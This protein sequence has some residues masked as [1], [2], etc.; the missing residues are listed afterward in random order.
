MLMAGCSCCRGRLSFCHALRKICPR[1]GF[2]TYNE[3]ARGLEYAILCGMNAFRVTI[4]SLL[5]IAVGLMFY[6]VFVTLPAMQ[7][8]QNIYN[9]SRQA[10]QNQ[11]QTADHRDRVS[12]Y[13]DGAEAT[14][15]QQAVA[16]AE[17]V[18]REA[19]KSV[20]EAEE[21]A[22]LDEARRKAQA[23]QEQVPA[24]PKTDGAIGL[25]TSFN[26]EWVSILFKPAVKDVLPE[27]LVIAVRREGLVLCEATVD[28]K[29]EESGQVGATLRPQEFGKGQVD[30]DENALLPRPGDEV[31]YSPFASARD[32]R[33]ENTFLTPQPLT[34]PAPAEEPA[35]V[36]PAPAAEPAPAEQP[37]PAAEP[38]EITDL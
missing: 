8:D 34:V 14:G 28:F 17:K 11:Q 3:L 31:V 4:L 35:P 33:R 18:D 20:Y 37:A 2:L 25:V 36:E 38:Y 13:G 23:A 30:V 22:V 10:G 1:R 16:E 19:E 7:A 29:D 5:V 27:G 32:L 26:K 24:S 12:A 9:I 15:L 21:K 6:V